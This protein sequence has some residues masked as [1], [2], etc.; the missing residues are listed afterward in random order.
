ME[1]SCEGIKLIDKKPGI[2]YIRNIEADKYY[3]G[4][5]VNLYN[6]LQTHL[7][8][9]K[10]NKMTNKE[11]QSDFNN[12]AQFDCSPI[13]YCEIKD[14]LFYEE[15]FFKYYQNLSKQLYNKISIIKL[16]YNNDFISNM[17]KFIRKID[18]SN[19]CW[20]YNNF[21]KNEYVRVMFNNK[22]YVLSRLIHYYFNK[23]ERI[24]YSHVIHSCDNKY[25]VRPEHLSLGSAHDNHIDRANK[26]IGH[27]CNYE[28]AQFIRNEFIKNTNLLTNDLI[29]IVIEKFNVVLKY[30][31]VD[32]ILLNKQYYDK[33]WVCPV[34]R[35]KILNKEKVMEI[36][37]LFLNGVKQSEIARA[38]NIK[39]D[40]L[41][42]VVRNKNWKDDNYA[43]RLEEFK[44]CH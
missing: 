36:R 20:C 8:R 24:F 13:I 12:K 38:Y 25:C 7:N 42:L 3:L 43:Q 37:E 1:F 17:E 33:D 5:S 39:S 28:I 9:L 40:T 4:S 27:L 6:R 19:D 16:E 22:T 30:N 14:L 34:N 18:K 35:H 10:I 2:Y 32:N 31:S 11:L 21:K 29:K 44:K 23:D 41:N 15:R 26:G